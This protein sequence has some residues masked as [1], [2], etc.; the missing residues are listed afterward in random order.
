V[1]VAW[2]LRPEDIARLHD[3]ERELYRTWEMASPGIPMPW[4]VTRYSGGVSFLSDGALVAGENPEYGEPHRVSMDQANLTRIAQFYN[5]IPTLL[6][7]IAAQRALLSAQVANH[8]RE[9]SKQPPRYAYGDATAEPVMPYGI[10]TSD[11][12]T[13]FEAAL[14]RLN[15]QLD[16]GQKEINLMNQWAEQLDKLWEALDEF[17]D[18]TGGR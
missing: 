8:V 4:S 10:D 6:R 9:Q 13:S 15:A 3:E 2:L 1:S 12:P 18:R 17:R 7:T 11:R 14:L 5:A 16:A